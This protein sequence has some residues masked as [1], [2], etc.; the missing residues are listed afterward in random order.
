MTQDDDIAQIEEAR[1][2]ARLSAP[3]ALTREQTAQTSTAPKT[4]R[5]SGWHYLK[6]ASWVAPVVGLVIAGV[7]WYTNRLDTPASVVTRYAHTT[8]VE[9]RL[10][11]IRHPEQ[12]REKLEQRYPKHFTP[13]KLRIEKVGPV[14]YPPGWQGVLVDWS[15]KSLFFYLEPVGESWLI[16]WPSLVEYSDLPTATLMATRPTV[17]TR[18]RCMA[19]ISDYYNYDYLDAQRTHWSFRLH[20]ADSQT[21]MIHAYV[22]KS[23][24]LGARMFNAHKDGKSHPCVVD[25]TFPVNDPRGNCVELVDAP[26]IDTHV[27]P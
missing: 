22:T 2:K 19:E 23:S 27:V 26:G 25:I 5:R 13:P 15:G 4:I 3:P 8:T 12:W 17:P 16:D 6:L 18:M 11:L 21:A 24:P 1:Y 20:P 14:K 9:A 10:P 7:M